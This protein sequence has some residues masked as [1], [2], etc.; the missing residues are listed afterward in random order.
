MTRYGVLVYSP[1]PSGAVSRFAR[2][3]QRAGFTFQPGA[4]VFS[5]RGDVVSTGPFHA[6][7]PVAAG[8]FVIEAP[9]LDV[10]LA[11]ARSDPA[12]CGGGVEVR[13]LFE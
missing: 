7:G 3:H 9:D 13:P 11:V 12:T 5:I 1:A 8:F 4:T 6:G 2:E 10:V